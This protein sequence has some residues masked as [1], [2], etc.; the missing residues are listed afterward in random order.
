[1]DATRKLIVGYDLCEDY[2]QISCYSYKSNE[3]I[4][5]SIREEDERNLIPT[6]LCVNAETKQWLFG[7]EAIVCAS[8]NAGI[9]VNQLDLFACNLD[10]EISSKNLNAH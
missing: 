9:A 2:T 10:G 8:A 5:I 6:A 3:P 1:M 4:P 7:E